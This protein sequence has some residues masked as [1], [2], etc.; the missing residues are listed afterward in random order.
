MTNTTTWDAMEWLFK[1]A[2]RTPLNIAPERG[3]QLTSE[4]IGED[5]WTIER[6]DQPAQFFAIPEDKAIYLTGAGQASLWCLSYVA[7]HVMDFASRIQRAVDYDK[8]ACIDIG[9]YFA[10]LHLGEYIAFARSLVHADRPWPSILKVPT[11]APSEESIEWRINNVYLGALSWIL[12]H[13]IGHV[14]HGDQKFVP[15]SISLRQE[16]GADAFAT[17]WILDNAGQGLQREFRVLMI[18]VALTWLFVCESERKGPGTTHPR[19]ILRF[20][21]VVAHF[22][23]G[24]RSA[25]LENAFYLFKAVLDPATV[26]PAHDTPREAFEWMSGR[27]EELFPAA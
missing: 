10:A 1:I 3:A 4:V 26:P 13:E 22:E 12:L 20:R 25:G 24:E 5:T 8:D 9:Q 2:Q 19:T 18:A 6:S 27:L 7:F 17:K 23:A 16:H 21:E 15:S 14:H 11:N